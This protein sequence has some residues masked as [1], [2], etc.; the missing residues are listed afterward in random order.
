MKTSHSK[1][2][3]KQ[4]NDLGITKTTITVFHVGQHKYTDL[5]HAVEEATRNKKVVAD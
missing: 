2:T 3:D 4:L 1:M 5:K